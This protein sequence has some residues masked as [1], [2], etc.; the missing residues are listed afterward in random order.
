M[1]PVATPVAV[2]M[3]AMPVTVAMS[4]MTVTM[5]VAMSSAVDVNAA[6]TDV[7]RLSRK[8]N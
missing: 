4:V 2:T 8:L 1:M 5:T 7:D 6:R 3:A